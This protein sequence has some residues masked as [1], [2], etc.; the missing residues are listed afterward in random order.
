M[1]NLEIVHKYPFISSTVYIH[2]NISLHCIGSRSLTCVLS[3]LKSRSFFCISEFKLNS[4]RN[5]KCANEILKMQS[6]YFLFDLKSF[7]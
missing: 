2:Y 7:I 1:T 6:R 4:A 3:I 5:K